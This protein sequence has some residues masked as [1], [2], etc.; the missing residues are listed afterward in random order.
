MNIAQLL[1]KLIVIANIKIVITL[2]PKMLRSADQPTR[3][4]LLERL[5][6]ISELAVLRLAEQQMN[7]LGHDDISEHPQAVNM[8]DSFKR[9]LE[10]SF[11]IG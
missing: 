7:V 2:L 11:F 1:A 9:G 8:S 3:D 10:G 5:D 4:S 6:R